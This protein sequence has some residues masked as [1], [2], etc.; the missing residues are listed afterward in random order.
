MSKQEM[1][2]RI[3]AMGHPKS[4]NTL[5]K[6]S[7]ET[8]EAILQASLPVTD[9]E[10]ALPEV[11]VEPIGVAADAVLEYEAFHI[12]P[13]PTYQ[14]IPTDAELMRPALTAGPVVE[15]QETGY[16]RWMALCVSPWL[17]LKAIVGV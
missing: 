14:H 2:R 16:G 12:E 1:A 9:P 8:L 5:R 3:V 15:H 4:F 17:M 10:I 7:V 13:A 6:Y 11:R